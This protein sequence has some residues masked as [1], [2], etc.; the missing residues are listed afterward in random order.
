M[1]F[2]GEVLE[3]SE[4]QYN[5]TGYVIQF[6]NPESADI[7]QSNTDWLEELGNSTKLVQPRYGVVVHRTPTEEFLLP[8]NEREGIAKIIK[9]N[10]LAS[11]DYQVNKI[12]WL[13]RKDKS[14]SRFSSLGIWFDTPEAAEWIINN[15]LIV[16]HRYIGSIEPYQVKKKR[17]HRCQRFGHLA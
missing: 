10:D 1:S 17:C 14:P 4:Y 8:E 6:K 9:K 16:G 15:G 13:R 3:G 11:K 12:A 5:K 2:D 7:A